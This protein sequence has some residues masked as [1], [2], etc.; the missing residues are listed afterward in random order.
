MDVKMWQVIIQNF[1]EI[2][3][4]D[5]R[6]PFEGGKSNILTLE[7][8]EYNDLLFIVQFCI[9]FEKQVKI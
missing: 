3:S 4:Q 6:N 8:F 1:N 5:I 2:K 7:Y 9:N